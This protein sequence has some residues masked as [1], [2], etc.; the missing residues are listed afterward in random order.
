MHIG[1]SSSVVEA[2][3]SCVVQKSCSS[4][5]EFAS[6]VY[7]NRASCTSGPVVAW[8]HGSMGHAALGG[9]A[10]ASDGALAVLRSEGVS[11]SFLRGAG[12]MGALVGGITFESDTPFTAL[13]LPTRAPYV[14]SLTEGRSEQSA[15]EF[16]S[17]QQAVRYQG[18]RSRLVII[19]WTFAN[20]KTHDSVH[21]MN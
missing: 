9:A 15:T 11:V 21:V 12:A 2:L 1:D 6:A 17:A 14:L 10:K 7:G 3:V 20:G 13:E 18:F 16:V 8:G 4:I 5:F 19:H